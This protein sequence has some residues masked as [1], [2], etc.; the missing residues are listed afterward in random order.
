MKSVAAL[1]TIGVIVL[2]VMASINFLYCISR[3]EN[4]PCGYVVVPVDS[5]CAKL[6]W[7]INSNLKVFHLHSTHNYIKPSLLSD[8]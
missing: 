4:G 1:S 3:A 8:C 7:I 6:I 2:C 5:G